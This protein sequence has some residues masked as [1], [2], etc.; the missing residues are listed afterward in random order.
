MVQLVKIL[1]RDSS[2][3]LLQ[4]LWIDKFRRLESIDCRQSLYHDIGQVGVLE[5]QLA[6]LKFLSSLEKDVILAC[7]VSTWTPSLTR[8]LESQSLTIGLYLDC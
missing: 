6:T 8:T 3:G 7:I 1:V 4:I 2:E 5:L